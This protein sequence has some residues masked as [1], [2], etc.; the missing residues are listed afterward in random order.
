MT[1]LCGALLF[2][3][4]VMLA[5]AVDMQLAGYL[6]T[7]TIWPELYTLFQLSEV[8]SHGLG[9]AAILVVAFTLDVDRRRAVGRAAC[10]AFGAGIAANAAKLLIAR[11]R[12]RGLAE[13]AFFEMPVSATFLHWLPGIDAG[14]HIQSFPSAHTATAFGLAVALSWLYPRGRALFFTFAVLAG[15]QRLVVGAHF[16]T[17]VLCGAG[18]GWSVGQACLR[19]RLPGRRTSAHRRARN[20]SEKA[21]ATSHELRAA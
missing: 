11:T 13:E 18:L 20:K 4:A 2:A 21:M 17:D 10:A 16:L 15:C 14:S 3:L 6:R 1:S 8:F 19:L 12:P 7:H 9:V 5:A